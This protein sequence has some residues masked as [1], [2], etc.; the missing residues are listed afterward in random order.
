MLTDPIQQSFLKT[1]V[2]TYLFRFQ[3][4]M[5]QDF[6]PFCQKFFV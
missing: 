6:L 3:P 4:F 2:G 5:A 1:D